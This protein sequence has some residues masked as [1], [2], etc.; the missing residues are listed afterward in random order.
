VYVDSF[1]STPIWEIDTGPGT[2]SRK[3]EKVVFNAVGEFKYDL[4]A[5]NKTNPK[6]WVEIIDAELKVFNSTALLR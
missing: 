5:D 1:D 2:A 3:F 6:A 4:T